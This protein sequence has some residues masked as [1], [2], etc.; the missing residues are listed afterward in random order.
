MFSVNIVLKENICLCD[1]ID[2]I[3][4]FFSFIV[5]VMFFLLKCFKIVYGIRFIV[6]V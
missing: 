4:I 3:F 6:L 5:C 2:E 1:V